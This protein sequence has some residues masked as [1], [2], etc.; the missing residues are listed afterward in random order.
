MI[1][2]KGCRKKWY[3]RLYPSSCLEGLSETTKAISQISSLLAKNLIQGLLN[4][5]ENS[6]YYHSNTEIGNI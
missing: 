5:K 4:T 3:I 6:N 1:N 2:I